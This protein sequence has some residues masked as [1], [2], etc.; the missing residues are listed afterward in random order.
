[1]QREAQK[2][3]TKERNK[4]FK[5]NTKGRE[6]SEILPRNAAQEEREKIIRGLSKI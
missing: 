4:I 3:A 2:R 5:G 1:M 6:R